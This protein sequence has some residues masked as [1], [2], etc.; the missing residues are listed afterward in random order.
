MNGNRQPAVTIEHELPG[1]LRIRL[2]HSLRQPERVQRLVAEHAGV[3]E[4]Q[5]T[6]V[7]RSMLV[8]YDLKH[9]STEEI[10]IR[11][12]TG[13]SLEQDNAGIRVLTRPL[14]HELT[15][16]A[17]YSGV[18]L[19]AALALRVMG[20]YTT[21]S[22]ATEWIAGLATAGAAFD[23]GWVD[24]RLRG[25]FDPEVLTVTYLLTA[26]LRGN[27]LPAAI[28]TWISTFGRHLVRLP[29]RGI[30]VRPA[31]TDRRGASPRFEVVVAPDPTRPDKM[32]LFGIIPTMLFQAI[33]GKAPGQHVSLIEDIRQVAKM[34]N[35]VLEGVSGFRRGIPLRVQGATNGFA[36]Q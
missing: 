31:Q 7:S 5:Y 24:Y 1:R 4:V 12:A 27:A 19:L 18:A 16:S 21:A 6:A 34:H 13:L 30:V 2:S 29:A 20:K 11:I 32:T 22:V 25:N 33:T 10:V 35:Q 28:L 17:F 26:L 15:D 36:E 14:T 3:G 9:I 23:H 8:F